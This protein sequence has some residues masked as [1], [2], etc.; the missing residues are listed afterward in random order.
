MLKTS[1]GEHEKKYTANTALTIPTK[2]KNVLR[3]IIVF[4]IWLNKIFATD[5]IYDIL[6]QRIRDLARRIPSTT[7]IPM[8]NDQRAMNNAFVVELKVPIAH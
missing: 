3:I 1:P 4:Q 8:S 5:L 2:R 7:K 6:Q